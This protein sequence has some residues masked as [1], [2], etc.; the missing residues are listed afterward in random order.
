MGDLWS[1][2]FILAVGGTA[3]TMWRPRAGFLFPLLGVLGWAG[4]MAQWYTSPPLGVAA[5]DS[6]HV[7][8]MLV[9]LVGIA[10]CVLH[11]FYAQR[12]VSRTG[13]EG[14]TYTQ[15]SWHLP[16]WM[17]GKSAEDEERE[18]SRRGK[19]KDWEREQRLYRYRMRVRGALTPPSKRSKR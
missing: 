5:G 10:A 12:T 14:G 16:T 15:Q 1:I 4:I 11:S 17:G 2:L 13:R 6:T 9:P 18:Y 7:I 19:G 3:A 8:I